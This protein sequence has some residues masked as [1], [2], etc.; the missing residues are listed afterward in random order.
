M[1]M[2][3]LD[4]LSRIV[5]NTWPLLSK[6]R[7]AASYV[8]LLL[9]IVGMGLE[10]LGIGILV[11]AIEYLSTPQ[12]G[13]A[14]GAFRDIVALQSLTLDQAAAVIV[15]V[16]LTVYIAK[17]AF[18]ILLA[19]KYS[20]FVF[21]IMA[22]VSCA[23]FDKYIGQPYEFHIERN[24][25]SLIRNLTT[26]CQ[27]IGFYVISPALTLLT[28]VFVLIGIG[29]LL[30]TLEPLGV[31]LVM[32]ILA[33]TAVGF[34]KFSHRI[35][36]RWGVA[37][38]EAEQIRLSRLQEG[39]ASIKEVII[40]AVPDLFKETYVYYTNRAATATGVLYF[41][42]Q[43]PRVLLEVVGLFCLAVLFAAVRLSGKSMAE[44]APLITAFGAAAFRLIPSINRISIAANTMSYGSSAASLL[45]RENEA[46]ESLVL[47]KP[48]LSKIKRVKLSGIIYRYPN[49]AHNALSIGNL[50][51][52]R[53]DIVGIVGP[54]GAGK[55]T[56]VGLLTG[57][58]KP[59]R[60]AIEFI[61]TFDNLVEKPKVGYV[62]QEINV[63]DNSVS[64][65]VAFGRGAEYGGEEAVEE[66]LRK[67]N[68][69]MI[70]A[71]F[72]DGL[73][74]RLGEK[75]GRVSGGQRQRLG[76]ARALYG[77]PSVL[78]LDEA[79]SALDGETEEVIL[80]GLR[81]LS[82]KIIFCVTHRT[83]ALASCNRIID[84]V[85]GQAHERALNPAQAS[86]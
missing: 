45:A 44:A 78:V 77:D 9:M 7:R 29:G 43:I 30:L 42:G 86:A 35:V 25:T 16:I 8:L 56:L 2:A 3:S 84:V 37:R 85:D 67:A 6:K 82:D 38:Q 61:D 59:Q 81:S 5:L 22:D 11:P 79:T 58:L 57:L 1:S 10:A 21:G 32:T 60:G 24:S 73:E 51:F 28:E 55:S 4:S 80:Q 70:A 41:Q 23:L 31:L 15:G 39:F 76:I 66:A 83:A 48:D 46:I 19:K 36:A 27:V 18:M 69:T 20:R 54:S 68:I 74:S 50:E 47:K 34:H 49:S 75:G 26:E 17:A 13:K 63:M 62:P 53:G 71:S 14:S 33:A 40:Y 52:G 65:N 12:A 72:P 64:A